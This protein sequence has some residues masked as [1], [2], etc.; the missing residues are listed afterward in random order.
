MQTSLLFLAATNADA[1]GRSAAAHPAARCTVMRWC[2]VV[3][4]PRWGLRVPMVSGRWF[5]MDGGQHDA[6][7]DAIQHIR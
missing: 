6:V 1:G 2:F 5:R 3:D 7:I 4:F